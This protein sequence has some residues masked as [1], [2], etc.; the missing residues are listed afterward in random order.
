MDASYL[1]QQVNGIISQLHGLFDEIGV[2][3]HEREAREEE[4]WRG[5]RVDVD[6]KDTRKA[7]ANLQT[8][9]FT[10]SLLLFPKPFTIRSAW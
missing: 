10:S 7:P 4:V 5:S 3:K 6:D 8:L 2:S 1:S 9:T